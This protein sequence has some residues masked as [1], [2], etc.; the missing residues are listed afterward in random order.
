MVYVF[1]ASPEHPF[2]RV[3]KRL[4]PGGEITEKSASTSLMSGAKALF[5]F[6]SAP[7][8]N[9]AGCICGMQEMHIYLWWPWLACSQKCG[10]EGFPGLMFSHLRQ[11][12]KKLR[13]VVFLLCPG[14][15]IV[16]I[17][18]KGLPLGSWKAY[19]KELPGFTWWGSSAS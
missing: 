3:T 5:L 7:C 13:N 1:Q 15:H 18:S 19:R 14:E 17:R 9:L 4:L 8:S 2:G 11:S 6:Q 12:R 10:G 16:S